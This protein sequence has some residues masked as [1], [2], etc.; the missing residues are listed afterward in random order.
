MKKS[1]STKR[2]L[3]IKTR[4]NNDTRLKEHYKIYCKILSRVISTAKKL[5]LNKII[6]TSNNKTKQL[7][8]L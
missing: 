7:G 1:C 2:E 6:E 5:Y 8:K 4:N 3:Y